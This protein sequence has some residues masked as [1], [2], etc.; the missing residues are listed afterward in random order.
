MVSAITGMMM[1]SISTVETMMRRP[2]WLAMSPEGFN[3][4]VLQPARK[5]AESSRSARRRVLRMCMP[6]EESAKAAQK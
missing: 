5:M 6:G 2:C 3:S 4:T 1:I